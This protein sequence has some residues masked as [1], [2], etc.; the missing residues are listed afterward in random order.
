MDI[1]PFWYPKFWQNWSS[2]FPSRKTVPLQSSVKKILSFLVGVE[3]KPRKLC[4]G[5]LQVSIKYASAYGQC[6][7]PSLPISVTIIYVRLE[8]AVERWFILDF[9]LGRSYQGT[10]GLKEHKA[11]LLLLCFCAIS[12]LSW[13]MMQ[14]LERKLGTRWKNVFWL[15]CYFM[16][17]LIGQQSSRYET[18]GWVWH[19][20]PCQGVHTP[21][22]LI[23]WKPL[24]NISKYNRWLLTAP[25]SILPYISKQLPL[26]WT[27]LHS[28][29]CHRRSKEV[30]SQWKILFCLCH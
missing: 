8:N 1:S 3:M 6:H 28:I 27:C 5:F 2:L 11:S 7:P 15:N 12:G 30:R 24:K 10:A 17:G 20:P 25:E 19:M 14:D 22:N 4:G 16:T 21:Q 9:R 18:L 13:E 29:N 26:Q 23:H